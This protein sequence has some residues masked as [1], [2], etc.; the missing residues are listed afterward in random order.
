MKTSHSIRGENHSVLNQKHSRDRI[1]VIVHHH[2]S[3]NHNISNL[4]L[5]FFIPHPPL[6]PTFSFKSPVPYPPQNP[7]MLLVKEAIGGKGRST[8]KDRNGNGGSPHTL[9][10]QV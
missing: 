6:Y 10:D 4:P 5:S 8:N 2:R 3:I 9:C 7:L 1:V